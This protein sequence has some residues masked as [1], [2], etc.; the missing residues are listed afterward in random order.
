MRSGAGAT[1]WGGET[2]LPGPLPSAG[3]GMQ[4]W[5]CPAT[6]VRSWWGG[7]LGT[8]ESKWGSKI[9]QLDQRV[10]QGLLSSGGGDLQRDG[11]CSTSSSATSHSCCCR[12]S[13]PASATPWS[14]KG[15]PCLAAPWRR[16]SHP[17]Q[18]QK[19]VHLASHSAWGM[20]WRRPRRQAEVLQEV[21]RRGWGIASG[22]WEQQPPAGTS[23]LRGSAFPCPCAT[24][25]DSS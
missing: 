5:P 17:L 22:R 2:R 11:G 23:I 1:K 21:E 12:C 25:G 9:P 15:H 16:L 7:K 13:G 19:G 20:A 3:L 14:P 18:L 24:A 8:P 4:G 10:F 6:A